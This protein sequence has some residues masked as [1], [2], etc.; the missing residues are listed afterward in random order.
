MLTSY[1]TLKYIYTSE[2]KKEI[3]IDLDLE[4]EYK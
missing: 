2:N 3:E 4:N 1:F